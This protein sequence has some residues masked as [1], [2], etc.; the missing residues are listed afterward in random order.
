MIKVRRA[1]EIY[2]KDGGWF[3][4]K[5]H[6]SFDDY[7]DPQNMSFGTL[8]VFNDDTLV[9]GAIWPMHPHRN[10]EALTYVPEGTF[11]HE[12][13]LGNVYSMPAGSVQR[14]TLGKGA[15]HSEQ[16]GS[17]T[18]EVRFIQIW[19]I[20]R[21]TGLEPSVESRET[22]SEER[23]NRLLRVI[24]PDCDGG[25]LLVHQDA[26]MYVSRLEAGRSAGHEF[27]PD[28]GGYLL[29]LDGAVAVNGEALAN[30]DAAMVWDEKRI[31]IEATETSEFVMMDVRV[32]ARTE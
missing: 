28:F 20:P 12:D 18:D 25:S 5:W 8:R 4:A 30:G 1:D 11:R 19:V 6:F 15:Y 9:P 23:T 27:A 7:Y 17:Q 26:A 22:T 32:K 13:S 31:T 14:M 21:E 10:I 24:G 2:T 16:N 29:V 3:R